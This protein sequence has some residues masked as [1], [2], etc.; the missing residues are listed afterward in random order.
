MTL[1][2]PFGRGDCEKKMHLYN[3]LFFLELL[4][5]VKKFWKIV[6]RVLLTLGLTVYIIVA[7]V[8]YSVVQT[9]LGA[10]AGNYFSKEWG[11]KV[12]IGALHA[13]PFDHLIADDIIWISPTNDTLLLADQLKV[14]FDRF[15]YSDQTLEFD[16]VYLKNAYYHFETKDHKTNLQFLIDYFKSDEVRE[17]KHGPFTVKA[18]T[19]ELDNVHYRM[20]LPDNR[21]KTYA[22][23]VQIPHMEFFNIK[24]KFKDVLVINDDVTC[25]ILKFSTKEKSG[26]DLKELSGQIHVNS[27]NIIARNL[28][29]VTPYS[30]I[31]LDTKLSYDGWGGING[32]VNT[33]QHETEIKPGTRVAMSDVAY[34]APVLW[35]IDATVEA[36][37]T[38]MGTIDSLTTDMCVRWGEES[39]AQISGTVVGLPK[40]DT[41]VFNL[42][43]EHLVT[44]K[45]DLRPLLEKIKLSKST[46]KIID[47]VNHIDLIATVQGG[48]KEHAAANILAD[49]GLGRVRA[50]AMLHHTPQGYNI[51]LDAQS[52]KMNLALLNEG[53][54]AHTGFDL[55]IDGAW[56]GE[57]KD[58]RNWQKR[59]SL[60]IDGH[61][62][63]SAIKEIKL[64]T[65][66]LSGE[67]KRGHLLA[68]M[69][70]TDLLADLTAAVEADLAGEEKQYKADIDIENLDI[71]IL[72]KPFST[73][74]TASAT[75]NT[76]DELSGKI[77]ATDIRYGD[78]AFNNVDL[79][80]ESDST[81][82][83]MLLKSDLADAIVKGHFYYGD[84]PFIFRY[85][86]QKYLPGL[87][88]S[89]DEFDSTI[90][91]RLKENVFTYRLTWNDDGTFLKN[92][93]KNVS[94]AQ[95]SVIDGSYNFNEQL[96]LVILSDSLRLGSVKLEG[97]GIS[98][99]PWGNRYELQADAQTLNV[100][101]IEL[102]ERVN[103]TIKSSRETSSVELK[104]GSNDMPTRG[105]LLF[106]MKDGNIAVTKPYFY[107]G[108]TPWRLST[109]EMTIHR[110]TDGQLQFNGEKL[111]LESK[112]QRIEARLQLNGQNTDCIELD[113]DHFNLNL[114][115]EM[116]LQSNSIVVDG[117]ING[118]FSL[119]GLTGTPY[120]NSDLVIDSCQVNS[121]NL[122][123]VKVKSTWNSDLNN[124]NLDL[125]SNSIQA[126]G[127]M[128]LGKK[129][130]E[131][132]FKI[133]F[134]SLELALAAPL[135]SAF[136]SR[137]EGKLHGH[138]DI[139]GD[140][141]HPLF[142][143]EAIVEDGAMKI[144]ITDVTYHFADSLNFKNN[145]ITL[146]DFDIYDP[147][148]NMATANGTITLTPDKKVM[149]DVNLNTDNLM[150][151]NKKNG[152]QFY[153]KILASVDGK[154]TGTTDN[155]DI[156][157]RAQ[158]NSGCDLTVPVNLQQ[159]VKSQNYITFVSDEPVDEEQT[160]TRKKRKTDYNL[161]LDLNITPDAKINLPMDFR[162][163]GLNVRGSGYGDLHLN[164]SSS[165]A[166]KMMGNYEI[167][168]GT[169][170]VGLLSVYEKKFAIE[171]GS[172]INFQGNV[173]D[174]RFDLRAVY[175]QR[176]NL[177]TLTG[178]LSSVDN[179]QKYIQVESVIAISGT[180][181]DPNINFDLR[182]PNADQSVEEEVFAYIDRN[183]ER[184]MLN[185]TISLLISGNFYNVNNES[186][187]G[188]SP[189]DIVTSFVGNSLTDMVQFVDVNIDYRSA[190]DQTNQ[191]LDV[192]IS[193]DWGRWYLEST[194]GYGGES[195]ELESRNIN[196]AI[197]DAL[198][199][200]RVTPLFHL[201]AYN[202]TNTNDYTRI[203]L[204]YKQGAGMKLTMDFDSW[205][206]L[207]KKKKKSNSEGRNKKELKK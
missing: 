187:S 195:R 123:K 101:M 181:K 106:E 98:G 113:F 159:R 50:D 144:D 160:D 12:Y 14:T 35:D 92:L 185:Q 66:H 173:P 68:N 2:V 26:F 112:E 151:L 103:A 96:K 201:F 111:R 10:L 79:S 69:E 51:S 174:A 48:I 178:S 120:F 170:K 127:W 184:D 140:L 67:L 118:H 110:N 155:L 191:Q 65:I 30:H 41:T 94:I 121:Q 137:F 179:T 153:G 85:F 115:S 52:D 73:H 47:A 80:V 143:G 23:G 150:V 197:I 74:L 1:L 70:S 107:V 42:D 207:F 102:F 22:Y 188:G 199:G 56:N 146:K 45:N 76:L 163:V 84:L 34:W 169:M 43:I 44:N 122:G 100:G 134:N 32:Y 59:L 162:E 124:L 37:G 108:K 75:G 6:C 190:T 82:K 152:D 61:F 205:G 171:N 193:K 3:N 132:N 131:F 36:E 204:P 81:G 13:M 147:L 167:T 154:V 93:I 49:C 168:S 89:T 136:S 196:G 145:I 133:D 39:S 33:V 7:L 180:L 139:S 25:K 158:T 166:A 126:S 62:T 90:I 164:L 57:L 72:P 38:A 58:L 202:R 9:Y 125:M 157:V 114:I 97:V 141:K 156:K 182:L 16:R 17:T 128:E 86:G 186:Q 129:D 78:F 189:L 161:E 77:T 87:F 203:D 194:L 71:G 109:E 165:N 20:D 18:K 19:L 117:D 183:S 176:A 15:P 83:E 40:I 105:D 24:A 64:S 116:I 175:S 88:V 21:K 5:I 149:L 91:D 200:Y 31:S 29:V 177:S 99:R 138:V 28:V 95:G 60:A 4:G 172:S 53:R 130:Q 8:N 55:S 206:D 148:N 142:V 198:I 54:M 119:Y 135:V 46:N 11:G 192:N 27:N 104:W 63:N